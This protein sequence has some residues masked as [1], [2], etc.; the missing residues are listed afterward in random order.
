MN[1]IKSIYVRLRRWSGRHGHW[2]RI[3]MDES[4][5]R[6][7]AKLNPRTLNAVEISGE[8][9][10]DLGWRSYEVLKY[11]DFDL[12]APG[13]HGQY[14]V[15]ICEQV[16]EHVTDPWTAVRTLADLCRPGG[17]VIVSTPFLLR[18][19]GAPGDYWRFTPTA[20]RAMLEGAGLMV[21]DV[22]QWG[23]RSCLRANTRRWATRKPWHRGWFLRNEPELPLVVWAF[24]QRSTAA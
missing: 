7:I 17:H 1:P 22:C 23:N 9:A 16:L 6:Y 19:H 4:T 15:V 13:A 8:G 21:V 18:I 10:A 11:P 2:V 5:R 24:A 3:V 20:L 14:D 12:T